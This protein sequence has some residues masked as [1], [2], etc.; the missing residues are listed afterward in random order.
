MAL[1]LPV[2]PDDC[3]GVH[4]K[5]IPDVGFDCAN[6]LEIALTIIAARIDNFTKEFIVID[7][8]TLKESLFFHADTNPS[9]P[10]FGVGTQAPLPLATS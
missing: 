1:Q 6:E 9:R 3:G 7:N 4:A 5:L 10:R 2:P 8:L